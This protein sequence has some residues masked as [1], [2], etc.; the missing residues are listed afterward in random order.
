MFVRMGN[1][2]RCFIFSCRLYA[3][4]CYFSINQLVMSL[5]RKNWRVADKAL[6]KNYKNAGEVWKELHV[7]IS[8]CREIKQ[9]PIK[10][11]CL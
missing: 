9:K 3:K 11:M 1:K 10:N 6:R 5:L 2:H 8:I 7:Q 4:E